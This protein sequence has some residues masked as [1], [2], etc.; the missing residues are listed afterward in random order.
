MRGPTFIFRANLTPCSLKYPEWVDLDGAFAR[1]P[2]LLPCL[3]NCLVATVALLA[4]L[5]IP[6]TAGLRA[7]VA[8]ATGDRRGSRE[9]EVVPL[10]A[11]AAD[12]EAAPSATAST[13]R[14]PQCHSALSY[15]GP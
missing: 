10:T 11:D 3:C 13:H 14:G 8:R 1:Y 15:S 5:C 6:E 2:Y 4:S 9:Y 12:S 7:G